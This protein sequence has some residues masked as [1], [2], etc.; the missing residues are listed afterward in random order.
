MMYRKKHEGPREKYRIEEAQRVND[1]PTLA[2]KFP[3]LKSLVADLHFSDSEKATVN[4]HIKYQ[5]NPK[6]AK[7][8]FRFSCPNSECVRGDFD[9]S[10]VLADAIAGRQ[11]KFAGELPCPGW[12]SES[13]INTVHCHTILRYRLTLV[14]DRSHARERVGHESAR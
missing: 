4:N 11:T 7:S 6:A 8:V 12:L 5:M 14:Y 13:T 1:S 10:D 3:K 9:L 2:A